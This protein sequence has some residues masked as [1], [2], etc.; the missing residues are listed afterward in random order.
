MYYMLDYRILNYYIQMHAHIKMVEH[1]ILLMWG[2]RFNPHQLYISCHCVVTGGG[3]DVG[4]ERGIMLVV[5]LRL[6]GLLGGALG[7]IDNDQAM[8]SWSS[9]LAYGAIIAIPMVK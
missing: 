3:T 2:C 6:A 4:C 7:P 8:S 9:T 1:D 5:L